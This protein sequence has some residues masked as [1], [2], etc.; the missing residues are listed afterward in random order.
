MERTICPRQ[1]CVASYLRCQDYLAI[2]T[3]AQLWLEAYIKYRITPLRS[4]THQSTCSPSTLSAKFPIMKPLSNT[5]DP[6]PKARNL[7]TPLIHRSV[8]SL[9]RPHPQPACATCIRYLFKPL[10]N[11]MA[12]SRMALPPGASSSTGLGAAAGVEALGEET[13][14]RCSLLL[15]V[16]A[17]VVLVRCRMLGIG[18][19]ND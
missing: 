3:R 1:A 11:N 17:C 16:A 10:V 2:F 9:S 14:P 13:H 4:R 7:R 8:S 15:M 19:W 5:L 6:A 12:R 18:F